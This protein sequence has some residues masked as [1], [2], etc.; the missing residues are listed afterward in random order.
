MSQHENADNNVSQSQELASENAP[1]IDFDND[2]DMQNLTQGF[3]DQLSRR[4]DELHQSLKEND[5][6]CLSQVAQELKMAATGYGFLKIR[7]GARK[8]EETAKANADLRAIEM[9]VKDLTDLCRNV[10]GTSPAP[11]QATPADEIPT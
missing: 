11:Q 6:D 5:L 7:T 8:V 4:I 9:L 10:T 1:S 2:A 3:V